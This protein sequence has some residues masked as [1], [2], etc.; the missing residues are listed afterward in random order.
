MTPALADG[1]RSALPLIGTAHADHTPGLSP[2]E[3]YTSL[4]DR[5]GADCGSN[6]RWI[7][8]IGR[9]TAWRG[10]R[11]DGV[12]TASRPFIVPRFVPYHG[13]VE[14]Y[15]AKAAAALAGEGAE[16]TVVM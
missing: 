12:R 10:D 7:R 2:A 8:A 11:D 3:R 15:T 1:I 14:T 5:I 16:V 13:G 9:R 4:L 6:E